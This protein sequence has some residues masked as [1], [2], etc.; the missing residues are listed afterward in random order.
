MKP[1]LNSYLDL[2]ALAGTCTFEEAQR[3][4]YSVDDNVAFLKRY[5]YTLKRAF[6]ICLTQIPS[7]PIYELKMGL[8]YHAY[9]FSENIGA[10]RKRVN[11]MREPPV[12]LDEV[13]DEALEVLFDE[14][15][16]SENYI[17]VIAGL[18]QVTLPALLAAI[19]KHLVETNM[20]VDQPTVRVL[21]Q[22]KNDLLDAIEWGQQSLDKLKSQLKHSIQFKE[23]NDD[24]NAYLTAAGGI[25]G[26]SQRSKPLSRKRSIKPFV[27]KKEPQRDERFHDPFNGGVSAET[28]LFEDSYPAEA[29]NLFLLFKRVREIDVPEMMA[30]IIL[31]TPHKPWAYYQEMTRQL[32]DE[33]RHAMMGEVGLARLGVDWTIAHIRH[34]WSYELNTLLTPLQRHAILYSIEQ[35]L[36]GKMGK[37]YEWEVAIAS[38]DHLS[39]TFHDHDWADEVLHA[40]I[41]R[42][43]FVT[44]FKNSEEVKKCAKEAMETLG[45]K[46]PDYKALGLTQH[47]NWWP[48]FYKHFCEKTGSKYD[49]RTASYVV[50]ESEASRGYKAQSVVSG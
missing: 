9:T 27:L 23:W 16:A 47:E 5:H 40:Q 14:I 30:T 12:G 45:K 35:G 44:E 32:W 34:V 48:K 49:E 22:I 19:N 33:A 17:E 36:M 18:Y 26:K 4:G 39:A 10:L 37:R 25:D 1:K 21:R 8:S 29:K 24:F 7:I 43:W 41:G 15:R 2:P 13:P 6:E 20:L 11:E 28:M 38:G 46:R 31:E 50:S 3:I 42:N